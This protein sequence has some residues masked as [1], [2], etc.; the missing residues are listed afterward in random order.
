MM[1]VRKILDTTP[2]PAFTIPTAFVAIP[3]SGFWHTSAET[4]EPQEFCKN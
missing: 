4:G 1:N 2:L 3:P